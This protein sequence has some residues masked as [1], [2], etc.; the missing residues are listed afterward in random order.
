MT[1]AG[2]GAL[3]ALQ[4]PVMAVLV[5]IM[6]WKAPESLPLDDVTPLSKRRKG[7]FMM[8]IVLAALCAPIPPYLF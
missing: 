4:Y 3:F 1:F 7:L 8:A 6:A 2:I 5:L